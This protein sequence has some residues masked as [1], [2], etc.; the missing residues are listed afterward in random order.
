MDHSEIVNFGFK[1][2]ITENAQLLESLPSEIKKIVIDKAKVK[3]YHKSVLKFRDIM[4]KSNSPYEK[5]FMIKD[6]KD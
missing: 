4:T 3:P 2:Y 5:L 6:L 1:Q